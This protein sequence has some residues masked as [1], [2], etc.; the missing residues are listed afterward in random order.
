MDVCKIQEQLWWL[1]LAECRADAVND[2]VILN[3]R[4]PLGELKFNV[5]GMAYE[6]TSGCGGVLRDEKD[7]VGAVFSGPGEAA[8]DAAAVEIEV[9]SFALDVLIE[10]GGRYL[11]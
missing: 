8:K 7:L 5:S 4:F 9:V 1:K 3:W 10:M 2:K 11:V 6:E